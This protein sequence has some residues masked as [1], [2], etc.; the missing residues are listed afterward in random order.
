[1]AGMTLYLTQPCGGGG[2]DGGF[3]TNLKRMT[4]WISAVSIRLD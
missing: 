2:N 1:M 3:L 4:F